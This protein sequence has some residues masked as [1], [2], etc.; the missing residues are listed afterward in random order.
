MLDPVHVQAGQI[1]LYRRSF[2]MSQGVQVI[3]HPVRDI[4]QAKS[5]IASC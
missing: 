1:T 2:F 3:I 4:A 5:Y